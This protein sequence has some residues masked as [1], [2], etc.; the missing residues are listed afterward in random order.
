MNRTKTAEDKDSFG[1]VVGPWAL[2]AAVVAG[3]AVAWEP[4]VSSLGADQL[5]DSPPLAMGGALSAAT[6][7][8]RV[9]RNGVS[10]S[11][12]PDVA[13]SIAVGVGG[14]AILTLLL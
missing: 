10:E 5:A 8:E 2:Y 13:R 9:F 1:R 6:L 4:I 11:G 3:V 7:S 14:G 12:W